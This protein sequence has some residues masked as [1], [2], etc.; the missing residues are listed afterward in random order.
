MGFIDL[1]CHTTA[2][3]GSLTPTELVALAA[4]RGLRI[5]SITD[6]DTTAGIDEA[7]AAGL[8]YG[9]E[10]I[11]GVE[12]NTDVPQGEVHVL[13]YFVDWKDPT[14]QATLS[15][16]RAGRV[17]RA[18]RMVEK[19]AALGMPISWERV[20][21]IAGDGA[22]GRPHVAQALLEA[23]YVASTAEAFDRFIGRTGPAY[24]ERTRMTPAE[25][26]RVIRA[27]RGLPVLAHPVIAGAAE[28]ISEPLDLESL[29]DELTAAGLVGIE[30][31]YPGYP[32]EVTQDL[33]GLALKYGLIATGGSDFHGP[34]IGHGELGEVDVPAEVVELLKQLKV[35][36]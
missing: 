13:G 28:A 27:A 14:L 31:Y 2:S 34:G 20:K 29:L 35:Q 33:L 17:G 32:P 30:A 25:A 21:A 16:L 3:D 7:L 4:R 18:Q 6:H 24:V 22:I 36:P 12:I 5:I 11:P 1:Q 8:R 9:I 19:L 10:V 23:G 15:R 26:T